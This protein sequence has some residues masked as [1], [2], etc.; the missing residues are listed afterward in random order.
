MHLDL[1]HNFDICK[2]HERYIHYVL[3]TDISPQNA[4][5]A[6]RLLSKGGAHLAQIPWQAGYDTPLRS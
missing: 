2:I 5:V 4:V 1:T 3:K 6:N